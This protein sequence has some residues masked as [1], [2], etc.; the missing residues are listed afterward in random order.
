MVIDPNGD[1][2]EQIR[3]AIKGEDERAFREL[4]KAGAN[5]SYIDKNGFS[6]LHLAAMFNRLDMVIALVKLGADLKA[7]TPAGETAIEL[8]P[9]SLKIKMSQSNFAL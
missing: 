2:N 3:E 4:L 8:A 1:L 5:P 6:L 7:K 9:D